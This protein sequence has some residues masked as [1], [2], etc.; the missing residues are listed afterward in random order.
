MRFLSIALVA[1]VCPAQQ[2]WPYLTYFGGL[3]SENI[4]FVS[5]DGAGGTVLAGETFSVG[6]PFSTLPP[7]FRSTPSIFVARIDAAGQLAFA[8]IVG[9]GRVGAISVDLD[10]KIFVAG[11]IQVATDFTTPGVFQRE[12]NVSQAFVAKFSPV[13]EKLFAT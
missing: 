5:S 8:N 12:A 13:G 11:T 9:D 7:G 2:S 10:G 3:G 6:P 1:A 4:R